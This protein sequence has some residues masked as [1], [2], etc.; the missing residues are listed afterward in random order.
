MLWHNP[1]GILDFIGDGWGILGARKRDIVARVLSGFLLCRG[2]K[3]FAAMARTL[4]GEQR[5]RASVSKVFN[6]CHFATR[7]IYTRALESV[8]S[9][10]APLRKRKSR[11]WVAILD[12]VYTQ[13]G[14]FAKI[15]NAREFRHKRHGKG[16]STKAHTFLMGLLLTDTGMRLPL[17][18]RSWYTKAYCRKHRRP[19]VTMTALMKLMLE[20]L[21]VPEDVQVVVLADEYF[22]GSVLHRTCAA[23]HMLY[24]CPIN[25]RRCFADPKGN[26]TG[27][28]LYDRGL[29]LPRSALTRVILRSPEDATAV[30][31]RRTGKHHPKRVYFATS[32]VRGVSTLGDVRIAYSWKTQTHRRRRSRRTFKVLVSNALAWSTET[33]IEFYELRWQIEIFFRELKSF[34]GIEDFTGAAFPAYERFVDMALLAYLFLES[35]RAHHFHAAPS[36]PEKARFSSARAGTLLNLFHQ[37]ASMESL[38]DL[39]ASLRSRKDLRHV[40][41]C[42]ERLQRA[43]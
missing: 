17:P 22:E 16:R 35:W 10:I 34:L 4:A 7:D 30:Y 20:T 25:S 33:L 18:R 14:G 29:A 42:L 37:E 43:A 13:R 26:P 36:L 27:E 24:I 28:T 6:R 5:H 1:Q 3:S 23:L 2:K 38:R 32:E 19:Y 21:K 12:G 40:I 8:L 39:T 11:Q 9:G 15:E 31:R 41:H